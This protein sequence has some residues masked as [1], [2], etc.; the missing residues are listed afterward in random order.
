M[1]YPN[2]VTQGDITA[3]SSDSSYPNRHDCV[4][5]F[6]MIEQDDYSRRWFYEDLG[7]RPYFRSDFLDSFETQEGW[8][9]SAACYND[10][11]LNPDDAPRLFLVKGGRA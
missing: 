11:A 5:C 7:H 3:L 2:G 10:H 1:N 6:R 9:C 4:G 8:W